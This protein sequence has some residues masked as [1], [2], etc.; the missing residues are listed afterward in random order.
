M[1]KGFTLIEII[2]AISIVLLIGAGTTFFVINNKSDNKIEKLTKQILEAGNVYINTENDKNGN[3]YAKQILNG[4][5]GVKIPVSNLKNSGYITEKQ[6]NELYKYKGEPE[7]GQDYFVAFINGEGTSEDYCK[8]GSTLSIASWTMSIG[9]NLY[10]CNVNNDEDTKDEESETLFQRLLSVDCPAPPSS[11]SL[12]SN[13][14]TKYVSDFS[15]NLNSSYGNYFYDSAGYVVLIEKGGLADY[16][17]YM[18]YT[19]QYYKYTGIVNNNYVDISG[20]LFRIISFDEEKMTLITENSIS[21][22]NWFSNIKIRNGF[23]FDTNSTSRNITLEELQNAGISITGKF[24][25]KDSTEKRY[26]YNMGGNI[27]FVKDGY[28]DTYINNSYLSTGDSIYVSDDSSGTLEKGC[29][30]NN[31]CLNGEQLPDKN[32]TDAIGCIKG[33]YA[34]YKTLNSFINKHTICGTRPVIE[35]KIDKLYWDR[36]WEGTGTLYDPYYIY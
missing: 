12:P 35:I 26:Y 25:V 22:T 19:N 36:N 17:Y 28:L 32:D 23:L 13:W 14:T 20:T 4:K 5:K 7:A 31:K 3:L 24:S 8:N 16:K 9:D 30:I 11:F 1:K 27:W 29:V 10:L 18:N 15:T 21:D 33:F 34:P 2:I 6:V